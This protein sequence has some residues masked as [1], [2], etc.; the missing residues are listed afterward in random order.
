MDMVLII[1][2]MEMFILDNLNLENLTDMDSINGVM[3]LYL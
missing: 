1:I 2:I 3:D